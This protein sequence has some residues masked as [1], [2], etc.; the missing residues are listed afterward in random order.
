MKSVLVI[1]SPN[2]CED[3]PLWTYVKSVDGSYIGMCKAVNRPTNDS[4][5]VKRQD[6]CPLKQLPEKDPDCR[7]FDECE[8]AYKEGWND[9]L[10]KIC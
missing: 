7:Y 5:E 10:N 4:G 9:C 3:C 1:N 6:W 8:L 2:Y